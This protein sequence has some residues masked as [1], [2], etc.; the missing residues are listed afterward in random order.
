MNTKCLL[1][2]YMNKLTMTLQSIPPP[3]SLQMEA[4]R[5]EKG[6]FGMSK[7]SQLRSTFSP[8]SLTDHVSCLEDW[9]LS[10]QMH[11]LSHLPWWFSIFLREIN[12]I[13]WCTQVSLF[14]LS[15]RIKVTGKER[16]AES[17]FLLTPGGKG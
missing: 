6:G 5:W 13:F 9:P 8:S 15:E 2:E 14:F 1:H 4:G 11:H 10:H 7:T 3:L 12:V 17:G 16:L